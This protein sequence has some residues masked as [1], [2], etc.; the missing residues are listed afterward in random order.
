MQKI[1]PNLWFNH[2]A[3]EAITFY[4]SVFPEARIVNTMRYPTEVPDFQKE[5]AGQVL[6]IEFELCG[7]PFAAINA[8]PE[9][10]F[11]PA[12]SFFV[13]FDPSQDPQ[14]REHLD[15]LWASL[16]DGGQVL[17]PLQAY[18]F[19]PHYGWVQDRYGLSWQLMLGD[20]EGDWRPMIVPCLLFGHTVQ[21]RAGEALEF[22]A[23]VFPDSRIGLLVHYPE[24]TGPAAAGSVMYGDVR[25]SDTWIAAMDSA[26]PQ[27]FTFNEAVSFSVACVDQAEIDR[28]WEQLS[29][30]PEAE[31]CGWCKDQF[32]VSWQI[33]PADMGELMA[34]P[35]AYD[36]M[37]VMKKLVID[38]F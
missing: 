21:N 26:V 6:G 2:N 14:A 4:T 16:A 11:T 32:G 22:Y 37:M 20:P 15:E 27:E 30:V 9:F 8:G 24:A 13:G 33:V 34:R 18:D 28:Y 12:T 31:Q 5:M 38:E 1:V 25:L 7:Q 19:S 29:H 23:S 35:G 3:E 17:M 36:H 10:S